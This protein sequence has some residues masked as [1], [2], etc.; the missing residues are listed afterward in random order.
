[1]KKRS[2]IKTDLFADQHHNHMLFKLG[3]PLTEI[4]A[5]IDFASLA[6]EVNHI[7][8]SQL[9]RNR[10]QRKGKRNKPLSEA[11]QGRNHR[12]AKTR[13]RVD[14]RLRRLSRWVEN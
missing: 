2:A 7:A 8:Q 1:M 10:V 6:A 4:E 13:A 3:D 11:Q 14:M 9:Y 5:C 12:I